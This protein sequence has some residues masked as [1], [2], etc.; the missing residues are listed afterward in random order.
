MQTYPPPDANP[1][2]PRFQIPAGACDCQVH[3]FGPPA[4][5]PLKPDPAYQPHDIGLADI[6]KVHAALGIERA[7]IVQ[8]TVYGVD[9]AGM[10]DALAAG[11]SRYRGIAVID[12]TTSDADLDRMHAAG[13]RGARCNFARFLAMAPD[14][15]QFRR[16]VERIGKRGWH[17]VIQG[18]AEDLITYESL[19]R[20]VRIPV[21]LD[22]MGHLDLTQGEDKRALDIVLDLLRRDTWWVKLSN[23]DWVSHDGPPYA[24]AIALGR[25]LAEAAPETGRYGVPTGR[26]CSTRSRGWSMTATS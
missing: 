5:Y 1:N 11:E 17:V 8:A 22:H 2:A 16:T 19:F 26:T 13:V 15:G 10:L 6:A 18:L 7:V 14:E 4:A 21:V 24:D 25:T 23:G 12:D 3:V 20:E 9:N